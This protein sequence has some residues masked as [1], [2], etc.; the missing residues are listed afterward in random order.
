MV[1]MEPTALAPGKTALKPHCLFDLVER[2]PT[3]HTGG[4]SRR[5]HQQD[6]GKQEEPEEEKTRGRRCHNQQEDAARGGKVPRKVE[7]RQKEGEC[8]RSPRCGLLHPVSKTVFKSQQDKSDI[9]IMIVIAPC[10]FD[11]PSN[12]L[13]QSQGSQLSGQKSPKR[14]TRDPDKQHGKRG[15][16]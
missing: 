10:S 14:T 5:W 15:L 12:L 1:K 11:L 6:R 4:C 8:C 3:H 16:S 13:T 7:S 2:Q 9:D